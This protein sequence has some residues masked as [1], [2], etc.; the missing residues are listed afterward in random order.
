MV[1]QTS[2]L[3]SP[4]HS[5]DL[6]S[7]RSPPQKVGGKVGGGVS[8]FFL[9]CKNENE[10]SLQIIHVCRSKGF[11]SNRYLSNTHLSERHF[12]EQA[13]LFDKD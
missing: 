13:F 4:G 2:F 12:G 9:H 1:A 5:H 3:P 8:R 7:K 6:L 10:N 11:F